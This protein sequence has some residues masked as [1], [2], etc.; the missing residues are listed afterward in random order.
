MK[1]LT[2]QEAHTLLGLVA[3]RDSLLLRAFNLMWPDADLDDRRIEEAQFAM[4]QRFL[5][6]AARHQVVS[7]LAIRT[8]GH[9]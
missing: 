9:V 3:D 8:L 6:Q 2:S 7:Q 4:L 1:V 5:I